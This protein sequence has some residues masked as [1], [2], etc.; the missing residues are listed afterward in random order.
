M[1]WSVLKPRRNVTFYWTFLSKTRNTSLVL[2]HVQHNLLPRGR[3][4]KMVH[5]KWCIKKEREAEQVLYLLHE[6]QFDW[7]CQKQHSDQTDHRCALIEAQQCI[8]AHIELTI[9]YRSDFSKVTRVYVTS[10]KAMY[11]VCSVQ[12]ETQPSCFSRA[13]C[14]TYSKGFCIC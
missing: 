9:Y 3:Q 4:L 10:S 14:T 6:T 5:E 1:A 11:C 13:E 8:A 7:C 12:T 2:C